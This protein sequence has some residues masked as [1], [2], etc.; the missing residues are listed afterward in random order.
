MTSEGLA[1]L[2][3]IVLLVENC[4]N[5]LSLKSCSLLLPLVTDHS[6]SVGQIDR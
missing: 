2:K 3:D 5:G 1:V 4:N 6:G